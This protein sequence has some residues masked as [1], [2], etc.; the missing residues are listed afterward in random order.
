MSDDFSQTIVDKLFED[1]P[2]LLVDHHLKSFN[3]FFKDGIKSVLREKN[4]IIMKDQDIETG[5]FNL[6]C[7]LFLAGKNGDKLYYG[8]PVIFDEG[9]EH[10]MYPNE[11]RLRNMTYGITI[12]YDVEL[13]FYI[14]TPG[15]EY[16]KE[17]TYTS[18]LPRIFLGRFPIMLFSDLCVLKNMAPDVRFEMGE[19]KNEH[20]GYFIVDG[21]EK[22]IVSQ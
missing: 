3:Y 22:V 6:R 11:A 16:P 17:P 4:P 13:E 12:H 14:S 20:G 21:K 9:R 10:F 15:E 19:C 18:T 8:R 2:N 1:N 5:N 7:N